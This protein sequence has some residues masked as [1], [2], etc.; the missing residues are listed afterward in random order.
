MTHHFE[1]QTKLQTR[2]KT[3]PMTSDQKD[4]QQ[5]SSMILKCADISNVGRSFQVSQKLANGLVEEFLNQGD[6][7]K[8]R[9]LPLSPL[10]DRDTNN[11]PKLQVN[12]IDYIAAPLF[13]SVSSFINEMEVLNERIQSNRNKWAEIMSKRR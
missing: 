12:F 1:L 10:M 5:I 11:T 6:I 7:E 3:G 2:L 13:K 4:R 8:A 9:Q